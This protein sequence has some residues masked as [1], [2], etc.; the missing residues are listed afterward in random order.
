MG[1]TEAIGYHRRVEPA[2][3]ASTPQ[4]TC[5]TCPHACVVL[6]TAAARVRLA[7]EIL[8]TRSAS[9]GST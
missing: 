6:C 9:S 3:P 8:T 2:A 7:C 4:T 1:L 5:R